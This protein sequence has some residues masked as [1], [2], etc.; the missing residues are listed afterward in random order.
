[1]ETM[2][3]AKQE[4]IALKQILK[5]GTNK[6]LDNFLNTIQKLLYKKRRLINAF[7]QKLNIDT[8]KP[9]SFGISSVFNLGKQVL[10]ISTLKSK[11]DKS[12]ISIEMIGVDVYGTASKL[13]K[14]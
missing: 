5:K 4:N 12:I 2:P 3:K 7:K 1:M 8:Q 13:K 14:A 6:R 10:P 11:L 9:K